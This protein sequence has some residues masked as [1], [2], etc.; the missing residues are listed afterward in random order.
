METYPTIHFR[1]VGAL[2]E[3]GR[4]LDAGME[5][6]QGGLGMIVLKHTA[7]SKHFRIKPGAASKGIPI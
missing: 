3:G 7:I 5:D 2:G 1:G 6:N 4:K